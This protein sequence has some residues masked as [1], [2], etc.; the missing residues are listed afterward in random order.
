MKYRFV[1]LK[2]TKQNLAWSFWLVAS[3]SIELGEADKHPVVAGK[4]TKKVE[5]SDLSDLF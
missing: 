5:L 1:W 2:I 3:A 4:L